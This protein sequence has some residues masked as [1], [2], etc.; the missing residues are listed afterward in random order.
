MKPEFLPG[1]V[2]VVIPTFNRARMLPAALDSVLAQTYRPI[3]CLVVDDGS[4]DETS[5]VVA[6]WAIKVDATFT[7]CYVRQE[8]QGGCAARNRGLV[9]S[10]G[11][12][13]NFLDSDDRLLP[14]SIAAKVM[15]LQASGAPYCYN[16]LQRVDDA[17]NNL[18]VHGRPWTSDGGLLFLCYHFATPGP[19]IRR[20]VC[21]Y[22]G[23]WH[24]GLS[25]SQEVEYFAR[26]KLYAGRGE[27][28]EQ[29]G[30][31]VL[32]HVG[33]RVSNSQQYARD[34]LKVR[35]LILQTIRQAGPP[36]AHEAAFEEG[37]LRLTYAAQVMD[38]CRSGDL[39]Q[40]LYCL[41]KAC[42][43]GY[44][45]WHVRLALHLR[46]YPGN[47]PVLWFYFRLRAITHTVRKHLAGLTA[48]GR[49]RDLVEQLYHDRD[50]SSRKASV[51]LAECSD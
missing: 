36:Y 7:L 33:S 27:F 45:P 6:N 47:R 39:G 16:L 21:I 1:L 13:I 26:L 18:G 22:V 4:T 5:D 44:S 15:C 38:A 41:E 34:A 30:G 28:L 25:G 50:A 14:D 10:Q 48:T 32:E 12:F 8:N 31:I 3:E 23:P 29:I 40:A 2:S 43:F 9:E 51:R 20:S 11:E 35:E 42:Q 49:K 17:G 37:R 19:L 24:D 46:S